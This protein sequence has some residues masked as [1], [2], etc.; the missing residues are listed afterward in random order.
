MEF[1]TKVSISN[2][3]WQ[4]QV[5]DKILLLGSCFSDNMGDKMKEYYLQVQANP[6]GT[7]YNPVS[8]AHHMTEQA[9]QE[10]DVIIITFGTAWVYEKDGQVVDNCQKRPAHLFT[11]RRLKVDDIVSVWRPILNQ[12]ANKRFIFTVSPIRHIKDGLHENTVSK[13]ILLQAVDEL[14]RGVPSRACYFPSYEIMMD[15]LRDYRFYAEDMLH[16]NKT[17]IEYLW[18]RFRIVFMYSQSTAE[19][20]HLL[21]QLWL[22][23]NHKILHPD[24]DEAKAFVKQVDREEQLLKKQFPWI[25]Q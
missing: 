2:N 18:E 17:A 11:R 5:E 21:H 3:P 24:S 6:S 8:I 4:I 19:K 12:Y 23:K 16:P 14:L 15:E 9:V 1:T 25:G 22:D 7:L 10:S 20:M 13:G